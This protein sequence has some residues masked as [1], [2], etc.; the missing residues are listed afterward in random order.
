MTPKP[1]HPKAGELPRLL[2]SDR[3]VKRQ[4]TRSRGGRY[5]KMN[6]C[7]LCKR[8]A[9]DAHAEYYSDDRCNTLGHGLC[10]CAKCCALVN[11]LPD[12]AYLEVFAL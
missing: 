12:D 7:E 8:P 1:D 11:K 5:A 2:P 9:G 10:L 6:R 3:Q 4:Q